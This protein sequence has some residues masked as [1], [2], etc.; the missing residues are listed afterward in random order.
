MKSVNEKSCGET[1]KNEE[2][3]DT[4]LKIDDDSTPDSSHTQVQIG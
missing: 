1:A 3:K 2:Q 4:E